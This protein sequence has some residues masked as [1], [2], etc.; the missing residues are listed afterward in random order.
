MQ[1]LSDHNRLVSVVIPCHNAQRF[2]ERTINSVIQQSYPDFE[3]IICDDGSTDLSL[4][5]IS[6]LAS[7]L[8]IRY[9]SQANQGV[10]TAR[11][12]GFSIATGKY[13][14]FLDADDL[15]EPDFLKKR[16]EFL[17]QHPAY[18]ACGAS[19][20]IINEEGQILEHTYLP[21][22][23]DIWGQILFYKCGYSTCPSNY[24]FRRDI[25]VEN[26]NKF[27]IEISSSADRFFMIECA[28][29]F[30]IGALE[31]EQGARLLYRLH[32]ENM[33]RKITIGLL[34]DNR[35]FMRKILNLSYLTLWY[36]FRFLFKICFILSGGYF[37]LRKYSKAFKY[38]VAALILN[39]FLFLK[40]L[41]SK[42]EW[43]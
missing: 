16:I 33:S 32:Q 25:L 2:I 6:S 17:E 4:K 14:L 3:I 41:W 36:K 13:I 42:N 1:N 37:R 40:Q 27:D 43:T 8:R 20:S 26:K 10:S 39:P 18:K 12:N 29:N 24:L 21:V 15:L 35:I 11:N 5:I 9:F 38:G 31:D 28:L 34:T 30:N 22:S 7:D 19:I 23:N